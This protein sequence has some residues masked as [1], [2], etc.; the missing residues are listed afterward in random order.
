MAEEGPVVNR[1]KQ[2]I[3]RVMV[4]P[5]G[6]HWPFITWPFFLGSIAMSTMCGKDISNMN[7][8]EK[9]TPLGLF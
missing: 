1:A 3:R 6:L 5:C 8:R 7:I 9:Q 2:I 4:S